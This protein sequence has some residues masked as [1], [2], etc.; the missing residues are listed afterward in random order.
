MLLWAPS[1]FPDAVVRIGSPAF[2]SSSWSLCVVWCLAAHAVD[3]WQVVFLHLFVGSM[4]SS[5]LLLVDG[6]IWQLV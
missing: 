6:C 2:V 1:H 5:A 3:A 4:Q